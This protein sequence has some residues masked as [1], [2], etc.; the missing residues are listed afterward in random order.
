[1]SGDN[2]V[3]LFV[4]VFKY[5]ISFILWMNMVFV[6]YKYYFKFDKIFVFD[7]FFL[8]FICINFFILFLL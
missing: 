2:D 4:V 5:V 6:F 7:K 3:D 8:E 1:M